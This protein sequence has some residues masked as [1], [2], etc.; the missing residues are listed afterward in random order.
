MN[1]DTLAM[2]LFPGII[3]T[4]SFI[5]GRTLRRHV[6]GWYANLKQPKLTPPN[7]LFPIVFGILNI[8]IGIS[9]YRVW[10]K[11]GGFHLKNYDLWSVYTIQL[12]INFLWPFLFFVM[13][14]IFISL[15]DVAL[16]VVCIIINIYHFYYTDNISAY[17]LLPYL[18]W[19]C[20]ATYFNFMLW[21]L[22][23]EKQEKEKIEVSLVLHEV[24]TEI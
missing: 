6:I 19:M 23:R 3:M 10:K 5:Q 7:W 11:L 15:I 13:H 20:V 21:R 22:N 14:N 16:L 2:I 1:S 18:A 17:L 4:L 12:I 9:G 8:L 24:S